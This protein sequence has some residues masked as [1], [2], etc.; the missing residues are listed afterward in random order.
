MSVEEVL[1][2]DGVVV[3][4]RLR[5][6]GQPCGRYLLER[7][8]V[9]LVAEAAAVENH[10]VLRVH[11]QQIHA[12]AVCKYRMGK[13]INIAFEDARNMFPDSKQTSI[14]DDLWLGSVAANLMS[15]RRLLD[16]Y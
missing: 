12:D 2:E 3:C 8:S 11:I 14:L 7:R 5:E 6:T 9:R 10:A 1:V 13:K 15:T 4:Q 16:I